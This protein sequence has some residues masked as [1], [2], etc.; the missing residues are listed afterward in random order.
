LPI[1]VADFAKF[2][3]LAVALFCLSAA[4]PRA[5]DSTQAS[6]KTGQLQ[7]RIY[8]GC[9]PDLAREHSHARQQ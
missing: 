6:F 8:F 9:L 5:N 2:I 4:L 3:L 7:C 1:V